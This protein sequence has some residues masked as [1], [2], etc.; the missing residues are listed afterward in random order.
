MPPKPRR[1][2]R[3]GR[4]DAVLADAQARGFKVMF[5]LAPPAPGLGHAARA[6]PRGRD[7]AERA[8]V[9]ALREAAARRFPGVDVWTLW[10]E[11]NHPGHLF[12]SR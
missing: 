7:A 11:P 2:P 3:L 4:Y 5:A 9:R 12:P 1:V 8:R 6:R 10:N